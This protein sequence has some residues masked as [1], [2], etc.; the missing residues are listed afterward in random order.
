M[1]ARSEG[2]PTGPAVPRGSHWREMSIG[3]IDRGRAES[4]GVIGGHR[5]RKLPSPN[6]YI[7]NG[8]GVAQA[9]GGSKVWTAHSG[10]RAYSHAGIF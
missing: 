3:G 6:P 9:G 8:A 5:A 4:M 10:H 1:V 2:T 7:W